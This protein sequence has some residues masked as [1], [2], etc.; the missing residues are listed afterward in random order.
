MINSKSISADTFEVAK[1]MFSVF[2]QGDDLYDIS[3]G[4]TEHKD[5]KK[6]L[7]ELFDLLISRVGENERR[8]IETIQ[9]V[10]VSLQASTELIAMLYSLKMQSD[11]HNILQNPIEFLNTYCSGST[12]VRELYPIP[13]D[14]A[15]TVNV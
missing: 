10:I 11:L 4:V 14:K 1:E 12:P 7:G 6:Y 3:N 5:T 13:Y 9:S 2:S 15:V 8:L